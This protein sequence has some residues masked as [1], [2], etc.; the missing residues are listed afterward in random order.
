[1]SA[2]EWSLKGS[3]AMQGRGQ[4]LRAVS[5]N[6]QKVSEFGSIRRTCSASGTGWRAVFHGRGDWALHDGGIGPDAFRAISTAFA[7]WT[8]T[9]APP[10]SSETCPCSW[11]S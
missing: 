11:G 9:S 2:R 3:A 8:S 6:A 7:K 10:P 1:M 5:T 4:A